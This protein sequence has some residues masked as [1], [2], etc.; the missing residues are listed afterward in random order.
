MSSHLTRL[1]ERRCQRP[2]GVWLT[3]RS[4]CT[5]ADLFCSPAAIIFLFGCRIVVQ[6][7]PNKSI[8]QRTL[9]AFQWHP[10]STTI[11]K[12]APFSFIQYKALIKGPPNRLSSGCSL[13]FEP[14]SIMQEVCWLDIFGTENSP[15]LISIEIY[16][17]ATSKQAPGK[18]PESP[19]KQKK[20]KLRIQKTAGTCM[21]L[22][23]CRQ[24]TLGLIK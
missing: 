23:I 15:F 8:S 11:H 7:W 2:G 20:S 3:A 4:D 16:P 13:E 19:K 17:S 21:D 9:S 6:G 1:K 12:H 18:K 10:G 24:N 22:I 5:S 14:L